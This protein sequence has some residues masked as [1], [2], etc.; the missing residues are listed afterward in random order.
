VRSSDDDTF[1]RLLVLGACWAGKLPILLLLLPSPFWAL[2]VFR[3]AMGGSSGSV[4]GP[5]RS[6][7]VFLGD[8]RNRPRGPRLGRVAGGFILTFSS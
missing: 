2:T 1:R 3:D 4:S 7:G 5:S 8:F 6:N